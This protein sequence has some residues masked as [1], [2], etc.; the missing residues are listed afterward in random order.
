MRHVILYAENEKTT[1]ALFIKEFKEE[2]YDVKWAEDGQKA[3][4]LYHEYPPDIIILDT[5]MPKLDG[6]QVTKEIRRKDSQTPILFLASVSDTN[7][8]VK[9]LERYYADDYIR[10]DVNNKE[11]LAKVRRLIVRNPVIRDR[12]FVITPDTWLDTVDKVLYSSGHSSKLSFR[13][14]NFLY[15]LVA[16]KNIAQKRMFFQSQIWGEGNPNGEDY[17]NKAIS[18]LRKGMADDERIELFSKRSG[19]I[20]LIIMD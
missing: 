12:K 5:I 13:E 18:V 8:T 15:L 3:I 6:Y 2:G 20:A 11:L 19:G 10:K 9:A 4:E 17:L 14:C 7:S 1:A 16:N